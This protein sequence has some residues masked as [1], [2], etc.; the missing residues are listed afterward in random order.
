[1][2]KIDILILFVLF[3]IPT[4][5]LGV[6]DLYENYKKIL[7]DNYGFDYQIGSGFTL[8]RGTPNGKNTV[9]RDKYEIE[10]NWDIYKSDSWGTDSIQLLYE[11][12]N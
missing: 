1:M 12:I 5:V 4:S 8:Q 11:D 9:F 7:H 2:K 6:S 10:V 3:S